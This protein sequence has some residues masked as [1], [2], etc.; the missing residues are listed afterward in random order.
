[1]VVL[2]CTKSK[3]GKIL[4]YDYGIK[5]DSLL[6]T[7]ETRYFNGVIL[8]TQN[9][10]TK[11]STTVGYSDFE[12]KTPISL[13][14]NFRIQSN[15]KQITAVLIM[16]QV[17]QGKIDLQKAIKSYLPEMQQTWADSV[18]VH[19]LLN[20]SSGVIRLDRPLL[21]TPGSSYQYSN[22]AYGLLGKILEKVTGK[23]YVDLANTLFAE[24]S[25]TKTYCF[26]YGGQSDHLIN[27]YIKTAEG[28]QPDDFYARGITPEGWP[29]FI[30]AGGIVSNA[31]DLLTWDTKLHQGELLKPESYQKMINYHIKGAHAAFGPEPIGY[32]YGLRIDKTRSLKVIG[33]AGKGI[34][35]TNLKFY[36]PEK[37]LH[38]IMLENVYDN[39]PKIVY[40]FEKTLLDLVMN[41]SLV[42]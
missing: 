33:H 21:F 29:D 28:Y 13:N 2:G 3:K 36:V 8:I 12:N 42:D 17:E 19:Q 15:S 25:M 41:S 1:M 40:H 24:L 6:K 22:A 38:V 27:G 18:T 16:K 4:E 30:P 26:E 11:Y 34:G 32:G 5:I 10:Q 31:Y 37:D 7:N 35:F 20:M 14:D 23:P 39:D 9:G